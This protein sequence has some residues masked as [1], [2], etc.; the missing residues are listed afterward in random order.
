[1]RAQDNTEGVSATLK[2]GH[3]GGPRTAMEEWRVIQEPRPLAYTV[4]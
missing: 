1:M 3:A 4:I 2:S